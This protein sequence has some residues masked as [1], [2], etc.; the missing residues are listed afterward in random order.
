M[1]KELDD[2]YN[3]LVGLLNFNRNK[4]RGPE[5]SKDPKIQKSDMKGKE[6][7]K[8]KFEIMENMGPKAVPVTKAAT[9][10]D[11]ALQRRQ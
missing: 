10:H 2:E 8:A 11:K 4:T 7:D 1:V 3:D 5:E 6:Y 9:E